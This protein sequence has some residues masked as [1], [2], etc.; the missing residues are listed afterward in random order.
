MSAPIAAFVDH[1]QV[2]G[3][4]PK[5][6]TATI[7]A[8]YNALAVRAKQE[9]D[10]EKY[11]AVTASYETLADPG[12]RKAF[13]AVRLGSGSENTP[14]T[15]D[16][17]EFFPKLKDDGNRRLCL[18]CLLYDRRRKSPRVPAFPVRLLEKV[19]RLTENELTIDMWFLKE[20]GY[21]T[22]DDKSALMITVEGIEYLETVMPT[23]EQIKPFLVAQPDQPAQA[24]QE[25]KA[26]D[27][28]PPAPSKA[29]PKI[30]LP[31]RE[32]PLKINIPKSLA[33][34]KAPPAAQ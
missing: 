12:G 19:I 21:M 15:F 8:A 29:L 26:A 1:Y 24:D 14:L 9:G 34:P 28:T 7:H 25:P 2:L 27:A 13:D 33:R 23:L 18:L 16:A 30:N 3:V 6:D 17:E 4:D 20:K 11:E 10:K 32:Q 31:P 22:A 5:A